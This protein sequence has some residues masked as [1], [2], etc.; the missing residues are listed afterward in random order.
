VFTT[1]SKSAQVGA[2]K[3]LCVPGRGKV[4][5]A[6]LPLQF[7]LPLTCAPAQCCSRSRFQHDNAGVTRSRKRST[8]QALA[9]RI[10]ALLSGAQ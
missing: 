10:A 9:S 7:V 6:I 3:R 5:M 1:V 4:L 2:T 8:P